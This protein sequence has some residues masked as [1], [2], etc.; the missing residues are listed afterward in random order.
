MP[1]S[2]Q[3]KTVIFVWFCAAGLTET[4]K[5]HSPSSVT[6]AESAH[7]AAHPVRQRAAAPRAAAAV[8]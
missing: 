8:F 1:L 3:V 7:M 6:S 5:H 2:G 4:A